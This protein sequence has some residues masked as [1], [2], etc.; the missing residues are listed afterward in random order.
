MEKQVIL[1]RRVKCKQD[2]IDTEVLVILQD[3]VFDFPTRVPEKYEGRTRKTDLPFVHQVLSTPF[4]TMTPASR[5]SFEVHG[6]WITEDDT[7]CKGNVA[8]R[9][10]GIP[11]SAAVC[12]AWLAVPVESSKSGPWRVCV[13]YHGTDSQ[14]LSSIFTNSLM[15]SLGQLGI[16]VYLGSFWKACRFAA[17]DQ[18]YAWR[19]DP[20]VIRVLWLCNT[21]KQLTFPKKSPCRCIKFCSRKSDEKARA[22]GHELHWPTEE[23]WQSGFLPPAQF[24]DGKWITHNEEWVMPSSAL[25]RLQQVVR[26]DL[27]TVNGPNYD[28]EQRNI[29]IL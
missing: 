19:K 29:E 20:V 26:I 11:L 4:D 12:S 13:G 24:S 22:C 16:G 21:Q 27:R 17:R 2:Y 23:R 9:V 6:M 25:E 10:F 8:P 3:G 14:A 7:I 28:P 15:P 1:F 18:D 5:K